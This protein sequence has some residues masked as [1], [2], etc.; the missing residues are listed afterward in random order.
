MTASRFAT[1]LEEAADRI[2]DLDRADLAVML[3][4]AAIRL[5]N[6]PEAPLPF[7]DDQLQVL[8]ESAN[9]LGISRGELLS[10]IVSEWIGANVWRPVAGVD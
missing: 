3:R 1:E 10:R 8:D 6:K 9:E 4:R 5:R 7:T 2:G